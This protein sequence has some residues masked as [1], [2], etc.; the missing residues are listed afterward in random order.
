[1]QVFDCRTMTSYPYEERDKNVFYKSKEFKARIIELTSGGKMPNCEMASY[2]VF[3][4]I[5]GMA[6]V[7]IHHEKAVIKEG[8]C[9]ITEPG[10]LSMETKDGVKMIG[11]Q[12]EKILG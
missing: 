11:I 1:M 3:F 12:I 4:V 6:E 10:M 7:K 8:Q 5:A 9:L 2:V